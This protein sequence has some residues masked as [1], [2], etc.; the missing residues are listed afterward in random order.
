MSKLIGFHHA[1]G[2]A[3]ALARLRRLLVPA[4]DVH[5]VE[6]P[7]RGRRIKQ[8]LQTDRA[9][10]VEQLYTELSAHFTEPYAL[11]GHSLGGLL[12]YEL[13]QLVIARGGVVPRALFVAATPA[14]N[15]WPL[16]RGRH[17]LPDAEFIAVLRE[18]GGTPEDL[19]DHPEMRELLLPIL[20]AD[21]AL[22]EEPPDARL[23]ALPCPIHVSGG[24]HDYVSHEHLMPWRDATTREFSLSWYDGGHFF[25]RS[26]GEQLSRAIH[27]HLT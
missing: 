5:L 6:L 7:G 3:S 8:P 22:C 11:F 15:L 26:H 21:F 25:V 16:V 2:S 10:L 24:L 14:P 17:L 27:E 23:P 9:A 4:L 13:A 19:F 12:A 20:R 18:Q 1:G